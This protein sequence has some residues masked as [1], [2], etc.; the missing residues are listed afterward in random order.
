MMQWQP[1]GQE[2]TKQS[3]LKIT[4]SPQKWNQI[5]VDILQFNIIDIVTFLITHSHTTKSVTVQGKVHS[6][7][8]S[9]WQID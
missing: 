1:A 4:C 8:E 7:N 5:K 2:T 3:S 9:P 6:V